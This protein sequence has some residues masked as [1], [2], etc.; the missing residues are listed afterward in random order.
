MNTITRIFQHIIR[1]IVVWFVDTI[2]LLITTLIISG[3]SFIPVGDMPIAVGHRQFDHPSIDLVARH[4]T[5][6]GRYLPIRLFH[7]CRGTDDHLR[8]ATWF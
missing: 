2:S 6:L 3:I 5:G 4:A 7:Q 8:F 1:F